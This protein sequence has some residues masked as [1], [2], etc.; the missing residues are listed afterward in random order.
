M[1]MDK[2]GLQLTVER[3]ITCLSRHVRGNIS[4]IFRLGSSL[5]RRIQA[6]SWGFSFSGLWVNDLGYLRRFLA[7]AI[8]GP[9]LL[10]CKIADNDDFVCQ[11]EVFGCNTLII[12]AAETGETNQNH[13]RVRNPQYSR[14]SS[15][16]HPL[17]AEKIFDPAT[18][19]LSIQ[20]TET[21]V[22]NHQAILGIHGSSKCLG[23][24]VTLPL[25]R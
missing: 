17:P 2:Q 23:K 15:S 1:Q 21:V 6:D 9:L 18:F 4:Q 20:C 12:A 8:P 24:S 16:E 14:S 3:E 11:R 7:E 25:V 5:E 10:Y 22:K 13:T 19:C